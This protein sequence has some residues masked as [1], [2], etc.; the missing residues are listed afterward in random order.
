MVQSEDLAVAKF[1]GNDQFKASTGWLNS[2][3]KR[4]SIVWN[5]VWIGLGVKKIKQMQ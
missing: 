1:L 4:R 5:G 3:K 2:F